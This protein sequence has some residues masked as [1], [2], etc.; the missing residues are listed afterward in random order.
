MS[1][2]WKEYDI[3]MNKFATVDPQKMSCVEIIIPFNGRHSS[4]TN[5]VESIFK[6]VSTN[7]YQ[8][9]LI[10][11]GSENDSFITEINETK[12]PGVV[13]M[14]HDKSEGFGAAINS[15]LQNPKNEWIPWVLI[16][17]SDVIVEG[18]N[19]LASLGQSMQKLKS[20][21]VK[22]VSPR[23]DHPGHSLDAIFESRQ[24]NKRE[25]SCEDFI[26][27]GDQYLPLYCALCHRDLFKHIGYFKE[28]PLAGCEAQEF[29]IRMKRHGFSQAICGSSWVYHEN[30]GTVNRLGKKDKELLRKTRHDFEVK[31][32][33]R[34]NGVEQDK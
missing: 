23:T 18:P 31:M 32:N 34:K 6:T 1:K 13:C 20:S 16:M 3:E 14:R 10:D 19:W 11:D 21:G 29:A 12:M 30:G 8:I 27:E 25:I 26:L 2:I 9:T 5:L 4:V 24:I 28:F 15:V 33:L 7:R 17:H 22:M